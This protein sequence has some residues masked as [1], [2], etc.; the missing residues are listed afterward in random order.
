MRRA[1]TAETWG[2]DIDVPD[3]TL[4]LITLLSASKFNDEDASLHAATIFSPGAVISG[5]KCK[6]KYTQ[7]IILILFDTLV[8]IELRFKCLNCLENVGVH[9]TGASGSEGSHERSRFGP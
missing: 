8:I 3:S 9:S 7:Q 2:H 1:A 4:Y 6:Y 5:C